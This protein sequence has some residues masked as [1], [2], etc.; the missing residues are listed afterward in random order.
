MQLYI[1]RHAETEYNRLQIIQGSSVDTDINDYGRAQAH[2]FHNAYG[3]IDFDLAV[4]SALKR[5]HQTIR[6]FIEK[7]IPWVQKPEINE[8]CWGENEGKP[9]NDH[10][11][12]IFKGVRDRW[13][14]GDLTARMPGGESAAELNER[15]DIFLEWVKQ[16]PEKKILVCTHGRTLRGLVSLMKGIGLAEMHHFKHEN[17]GLYVVRYAIDDDVFHFEK[18]NCTEHLSDLVAR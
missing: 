7:G 16:R 11:T 1:I 4:S 3:H 13:F 2:A 12:E 17:T 5:T 6:P 10:W 18:E 8:I 9:I 14:D 15:L